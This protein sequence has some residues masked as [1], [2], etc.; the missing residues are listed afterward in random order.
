MSIGCSELAVKH[1]LRLEYC[2]EIPWW[3]TSHS[4][5]PGTDL[6]KTLQS[7]TTAPHLQLNI[8]PIGAKCLLPWWKL[9]G[10]LYSRTR[11]IGHSAA[12]EQVSSDE[13]KSVHSLYPCDRSHFIWAHSSMRN[14]KEKEVNW[15][16]QDRSPCLLSKYSPLKVLLWWTFMW[17]ADIFYILYS[18]WE[19]CLNISL[20]LFIQLIFHL[21]F[22]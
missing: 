1:T 7:R 6:R 17:L 16:S 20:Q 11:S 19:V 21:N 14:L 18:V 8:Y 15:Q 12:L 2:G 10:P 13:C 3:W 9:A 5:N 4:L 22:F